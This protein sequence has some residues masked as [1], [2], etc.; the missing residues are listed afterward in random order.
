[1]SSNQDSKPTKA[2]SCS[3]TKITLPRTLPFSWPGSKTMLMPQILP[4]IPSH[5]RYVSVFGGSACDI[6][7][8]YHVPK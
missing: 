3:S 2:V 4:F 8:K 6:Y 1:M 5:E 7:W